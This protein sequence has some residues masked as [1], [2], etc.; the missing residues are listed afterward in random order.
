M[1]RNYKIIMCLISISCVFLFTL[2]V[3]NL[4]KEKV[5]QVVKTSGAIQNVDGINNKKIGWGIKRNENHNQPDVG[6]K[7][8]EILDK[9]EG[10]SIGNKDSKNVY[11]TF[12]EGYEAGYTEKIL[13][14]LKQNDV[15]ACFFITAHYVNTQPELVK[16]M[17]DEGHIIG[18]H[19]PK[20]L[21]AG[22]EKL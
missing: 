18:N 8:K 20:F 7:N 3:A 10:F 21:M 15:K 11:L 12:D 6:I 13:E 2:S 19:T 5:P 22:I 17:I 16:K 1:K 9:Y 14:V 4:N